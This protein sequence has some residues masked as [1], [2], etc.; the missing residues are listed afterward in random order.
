MEAS[1]GIAFYNIRPELAYLCISVGFN[2]IY[3]V[4]VA[5]R[6]LVMRRNMKRVLAQYDCSPYDTVVI[7]VVESAAVYSIFG[8]LFIVAFALHYNGIT[9]ICFLS[10]GQ[11]QVS[12]Q[13]PN[14]VRL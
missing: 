5:H 13:N 9:T 8:I 11:L 14:H 3:T 2:V 7:M 1:K 4:L 6:L 12:R 10:F